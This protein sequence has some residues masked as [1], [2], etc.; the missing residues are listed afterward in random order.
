MDMVAP[1]CGESVVLIIYKN[2]YFCIFMGPIGYEKEAKGLIRVIKSQK[3]TNQFAKLG[4]LANEN[5]SVL[6][7]K[8]H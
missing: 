6:R 3:F 4:F 5:F 7:D 8:K 2:T 1:S